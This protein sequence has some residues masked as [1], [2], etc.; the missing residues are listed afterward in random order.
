M[1]QVRLNW[2]RGHEAMEGLNVLVDKVSGRPLKVTWEGWEGWDA[3][4]GGRKDQYEMYEMYE[5]YVTYVY[6]CIL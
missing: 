4:F 2:P 3:S 1:A 6:T 5:T